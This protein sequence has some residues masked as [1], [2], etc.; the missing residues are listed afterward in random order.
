MFVQTIIFGQSTTEA[1]R[2]ATQE[3]RDAE[4]RNNLGGG[5]TDSNGMIKRNKDFADIPSNYKSTK[6][7]KAEK[8]TLKAEKERIEKLI[9]P[10]SE[11]LQ[12][13]VALIKSS[14]GG[15]FRLFQN[16][17][18]EEKYVLKIN[19]KCANYIS[20]YSTYSFRRKSYFS[21][22]DF[23]DIQFKGDDLVSREF[24]SQSIITN[25]GDV[26]IEDVSLNSNGM[27]FLSKFTPQSNPQAVKNQ[28]NEITNG[29]KENGYFY[30]NIVKAELNTT[31]GMRIIAYH[32]TV[33]S[34]YVTEIAD[35]R[36][37]FIN[38]DNRRDLTI[39]F[40]IIRKDEDG[41]ITIVWKELN[42]KTP[43]KLKYG[44]DEKL[45]DFKPKS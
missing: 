8:A 21:E 27:G 6:L 26:P 29:I 18:C 5:Y 9:T 39:A 17:D 20:G 40:R 37:Y 12:Q 2:I 34:R 13:Y 3:R 33:P 11:D 23:I 28:Y 25:L 24:L 16:F 44:K 7:S 42:N 43:P 19:E 1:E 38:T 35:R 14:G 22:Q 4:I 15:L 41:N 10:K 32:F 36:F 31:Y 45:E 30:S